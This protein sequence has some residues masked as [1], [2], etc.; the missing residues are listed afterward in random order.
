MLT[1]PAEG[2]RI[3]RL[4]ESVE[5]P[6]EGHAADTG[7]TKV[8]RSVAVRPLVD[9]DVPRVEPLP[10]ELQSCDACRVLAAEPA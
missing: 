3:D 2:D 6:A 8:T 7:V 4:E 9:A 5:S 1:A 10:R